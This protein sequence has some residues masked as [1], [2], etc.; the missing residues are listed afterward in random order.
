[1]TYVIGGSK[2]V[3]DLIDH[4]EGAIDGPLLLKMKWPPRWCRPALR[5]EGFWRVG[6]GARG[7]VQHAECGFPD[8]LT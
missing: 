6:G 3:R 5:H 7:H 1:M 2:A 8:P 4:S